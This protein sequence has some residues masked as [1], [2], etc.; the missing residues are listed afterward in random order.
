VPA[1]LAIPRLGNDLNIVLAFKQL[2][3]P[4]ADD[5]VIIRQKDADLVI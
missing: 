4:G 5:V 1:L 3:Y 2:T